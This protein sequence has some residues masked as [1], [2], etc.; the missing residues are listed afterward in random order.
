MPK[1][2]VMQPKSRP[3]GQGGSGTGTQGTQGTSRSFIESARR[4]QIVEAAIEVIADE[5]YGKASFARIAERAGISPGLISYHF[6]NKEELLAQIVSEVSGDMDRVLSERAERTRSYRAALRAITEGFVHY[7]AENPR[8]LLALGHVTTAEGG[9]GGNHLARQ[10]REQ[11]IGELMDMLRAGQEE[12][13]FRAFDVRFMA[14][15]LLGAMHAVPSELFARPEIDVDEY[16]R[17]LAEVFDRSVRRTGRGR[18][19]GR[20]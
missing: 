13:E 20:G 6:T 14:V 8:K 15:T 7:C 11:S 12:G 19:L 4:A 3:A 2:L 10:V 5:G 16:A 9:P 18:R 1:I 17:E